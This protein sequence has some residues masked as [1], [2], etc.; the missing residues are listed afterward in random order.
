MT[1]VAGDLRDQLAYLGRDVVR[2]GLVVG[3]GG[4]LSAR[5]PGGDDCW[6]TAS[7]T[8][9]DRLDRAS[10]VRVRIADGTTLPDG[11]SSEAMAPAAMA[12]GAMTPAGTPSRPTSELALHL[13]VYRARPDVHAVVHLH[14]QSMLLLDTLGVPIR[15]VTT[16]HAFYLRRVVT[17]PFAPPGGWPL[18]RA[19]ADAA[20][21][22]TNCLILSRHGCSVLASSV[23]LAHKRAVNLEEAA[24]L[25]Y[26]AL[27]V[28]RLDELTPL[29]ADYLDQLPH[30]EQGSV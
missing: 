21:D 18:A 26:R 1:Y 2:A 9:L 17:V 19:A 28:G 11:P 14:P 16:D 30:P 15:L 25:T 13:A 7:G 12:P 20:A 27:A 24:R 23:E 22:G 4:N 8:W 10:F 6:V 29:P 5:L 3:S